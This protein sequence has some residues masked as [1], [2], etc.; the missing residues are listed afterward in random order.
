MQII[1]PLKLGLI[2]R[3]LYLQGRYQLCVSPL[4]WFSLSSGHVLPEQLGWKKT[5]AAMGAAEILDAGAP[6]FRAEVLLSG[7]AYAPADNPVEQMTAGF[8]VGEN[9]EKMITVCGNQSLVLGDDGWHKTPLESFQEMNLDW[10]NSFGGKGFADNF[11]GKGFID[12]DKPLEQNATVPLANLRASLDQFDNID[13]SYQPVGFG[14]IDLSAPVRQQR[15]GTYDETWLDKHYPGLAPDHAPSIFNTTQQDQWLEGKLRGDETFQLVGVSR[16]QPLL[17]GNLPALR[18]RAFIQRKNSPTRLEAVE[19]EAD[20]LW[21]FPEEDVGVLVYRGMVDVDDSDALDVESLMLAYENISDTARPVSYYEEV[22]ALRTNKKTALAHV[23]NDSQ[24][25]PVKSEAEL[26]ELALE[27]KCAEQEHEKKVVK[28]QASMLERLNKEALSK[29]APEIKPVK[30]EMPAV[31]VISSAAIRRG[32]VD[33]TETIA[34]LESLAQN[35]KRDGEQKV[36]EL[37]KTLEKNGIKSDAPKEKPDADVETRFS[38]SL[39][40]KIPTDNSDE[41]LK[42]AQAKIEARRLSAKDSSSAN[43]VTPKGAKRLREHVVAALDKGKSLS[44]VD[45]CGADLAGL[46]FRGLDMRDTLLESADLSGSNFKGA[47]LQGAVFT[48]AKI[49]GACFDDCRFENANFSAVKGEHAKFRNAR[50][51]AIMAIKAKLEKVDFSGAHFESST[52]MDSSLDDSLMIGCRLKNTR[53]MQTSLCNIDISQADLYQVM[54][55]D[56]TAEGAN[57]ASSKIVRSIFAQVKAQRSSFVN[58]HLDRVQ[59]GGDCDLSEC[60]FTQVFGKTVGFQGAILSRTN[61]EDA[62]VKESNF[63]DCNLQ[64]ANLDGAALFRCIFSGAQFFDVSAKSAN[65]TESLLRKSIWK[66]TDLAESEFF[67]ANAKEAQFHGCH[68][69]NI[70]N[71]PDKIE[72]RP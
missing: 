18:A 8:S 21:F 2:H 44:G 3:T 46:D 64:S 58:G 12:R 41:L 62:A 67:S 26:K 36:A 32:D 70:K 28:A 16:S 30:V 68:M 17:A 29:G 33:L 5:L 37:K 43:S 40:P 54:V 35:C 4:M 63:M 7:K 24:L 39:V 50:F 61:F 71:V 20:T 56:V 10:S 15:A 25:T 6:K 65:F 27:Q 47:N 49:H 52:F 53:F 60:N 22:H 57:F 42:L 66:N 55:M 11:V 23:M 34:G 69:K 14:P 72:V 1:K 51:G 48:N 38:D 31:P 59:F 13:S 45:L 9:L 19:T